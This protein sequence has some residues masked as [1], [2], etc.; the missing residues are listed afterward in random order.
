MKRGDR[1]TTTEYPAD[2]PLVIVVVAGGKVA[3]GSPNW[4]KGATHPL[5]PQQITSVN[6]AEINH[7]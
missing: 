6:G 4:P 3:I 5:T 2:Y 7:G 1:V